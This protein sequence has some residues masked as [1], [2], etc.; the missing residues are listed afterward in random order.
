MPCLTS[1]RQFTDTVKKSHIIS[2]IGGVYGYLKNVL[3]RGQIPRIEILNPE[4][5]FAVHED[6]LGGDGY[7]W[8]R[9][10]LAMDVI[11]KKEAALHA[12]VGS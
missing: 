6:G 2:E 1:P 8:S 7:D 10:D 9:L 4:K 12:R 5:M 3:P 11:L